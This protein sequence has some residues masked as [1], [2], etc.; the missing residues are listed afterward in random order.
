MQQLLSKEQHSMPSH[1]AP[2]YTWHTAD[3]HIL[4]CNHSQKLWL[5]ANTSHR[6][7]FGPLIESL[8]RGQQK[9]AGSRPPCWNFGSRPTN[10][11][12]LSATSLNSAII[13]VTGYLPHL[14]CCT[15]AATAASLCAAPGETAAAP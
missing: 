9:Q 15:A 2:F 10:L 1:T 13:A 11:G 8:A 12:W 4:D 7:A 3:K 14:S 5:A 6:L